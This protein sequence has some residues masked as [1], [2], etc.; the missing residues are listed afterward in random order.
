MTD[1]DDLQHAQEFAAGYEAG[2]EIADRLKVGSLFLG[3][4]GAADDYA[5]TE[6]RDTPAWRGALWGFM[7]RLNARFGQ[8]CGI[9]VDAEG[10]IVK[11]G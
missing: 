7:D 2:T 6:N 5:G 10:R 9:T 3:G 8:N 11:F 4:Y 1:Q